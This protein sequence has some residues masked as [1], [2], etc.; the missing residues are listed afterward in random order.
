MFRV[1]LGAKI[2]QTEIE[3]SAQILAHNI[4]LSE[5]ALESYP[6]TAV[7]RFNGYRLQVVQTPS[8]RLLVKDSALL[9]QMTLLRN[10]LCPRLGHCPELWPQSNPQRGIWIRLA[11][12]L[13]PVWLFF[14]VPSLSPLSTDP[15]I[16][17]LSL[18]SAS[19]I[20]CALFL[21]VEVRRPIV[22]LAKAMGF[23]GSAGN[24]NPAPILGAPEV[25]LLSHHFN[26][27]LARLQ[28]SE[29]DRQS[30]LAGIAHDLNSPLTRLRLRLFARDPGH[31][32]ILLDSQGLAKI[33]ADLDALERIT[34]Q[35]LFFAGSGT[36]EPFVEVPLDHLL[37]EL[38]GRYDT[39]QILLDL[40]HLQAW[41][42]PIALGRAIGN[43]IDNAL[44]YGQQPVALK[45]VALADDRY[46][47]DVVD[48]GSGIPESLR[49]LV[50]EPFQR[51]D[52]ARRGGGHCG[53]G[54]A[55]AHRIAQAHG[56]HLKLEAASTGDPP[57]LCASFQGRQRPSMAGPA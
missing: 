34:Q 51:L 35:F 9:R 30:M 56:G 19:F 4:G 57:G 43:L 22:V 27:M 10:L 13:E 20:A 33:A 42:Q 8:S 37:A 36:S 44:E 2:E 32:G 21:L 38:C 7:S 24:C 12:T 54:L 31:M 40:E 17:S 15:L 23:V 48:A 28:A 16:L 25:R 52:P 39:N 1:V 49:D 53:L 26:A 29:Q 46:D 6:P 18:L 45:L 55:I 14:P 50:L 5:L 41:V 11:S 3:R 47:I